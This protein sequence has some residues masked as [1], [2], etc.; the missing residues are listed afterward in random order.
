MILST[1]WR[2]LRSYRESARISTNGMAFQIYHTRYRN[3]KYDK[4]FKNPKKYGES[5]KW[6]R[7]AFLILFF[8]TLALKSNFLEYTKLLMFSQLETS[9][10]LHQDLKQ[11]ANVCYE[12]REPAFG[13]YKMVETRN[14]ATQTISSTV[15]ILP[16]QFGHPVKLE[17]IHRMLVVLVSREEKSLGIMAQKFLMLFLTAEVSGTVVVVV[18]EK[19][20]KI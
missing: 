20:F 11:A 14:S 3:S 7:L 2:A 18:V 6:T 1:Y 5:Y 16:H 9:I 15:T 13:T 8:K 4:L 12:Q 19:F 10:D 17:I